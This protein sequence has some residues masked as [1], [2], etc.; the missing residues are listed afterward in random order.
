ME[1]TLKRAL[2]L[3]DKLGLAMIKKTSARGVARALAGN[4]KAEIQR[5][6]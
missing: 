2:G 1:G 4:D 5:P 3:D 6:T